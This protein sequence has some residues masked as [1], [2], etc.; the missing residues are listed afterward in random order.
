MVNSTY[1]YKADAISHQLELLV[2]LDGSRAAEGVLPIVTSLA[3]KSGT[4]VMLLHALE[5]EQRGAIHGEPHL[6]DK[7]EAAAYLEKIGKE[8]QAAGATVSTHVHEPAV[9]DVAASIHNHAGEVCASMIVMCTHGK[10][11]FHHLLFGSLAQQSLEK[12][13]CPVL[14]VPPAHRRKAVSFNP[15]KILIPVDGKHDCRPAFKAV[16]NIALPGQTTVEL[17][18]V[19]PTHDTLRQEDALIGRLLP[20]ASQA[21]LDA[22]LEGASDYLLKAAGDPM[23]SGLSPKTKILRGVPAEEILSYSEKENFDMLVFSTHGDAGI[24]ATLNE[25]A[26]QQLIGGSRVPVLLVKI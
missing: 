24:I 16:A 9:K 12:G 6:T 23:L 13:G 22:A 2:P 7:S 17:V 4:H 25:S 21:V 5:R 3:A 26:G 10:G 11:P 14:L 1:S 15:R 20:S 18:L 8:L 19:V